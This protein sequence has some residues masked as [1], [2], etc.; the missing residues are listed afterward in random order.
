MTD[1]TTSHNIEVSVETAYLPQES[2]PEKNRYVF[3]YTITIANHGTVGAQLISRHWLVTDANAQVQEVR[4]QGVVGEQPHL[5]P[6]EHFQY[7]SGTIIETAVGSMRGSYEMIDDE[8]NSFNA[9][10]PT[11]TLA[12]PGSLH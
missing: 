2:M 11:F 9:A 3:S 4:G 6:G 7:S 12:M 8:G 1:T 5:K 10:I